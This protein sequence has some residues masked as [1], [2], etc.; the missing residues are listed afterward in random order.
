MR[1]VR[2]WSV[3]SAVLPPVLG[4]VLGEANVIGPNPQTFFGLGVLA[5]ISVGGIIYGVSEGLRSRR[6]MTS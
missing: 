6:S 2:Y 3:L 1:A 5:T 4:V